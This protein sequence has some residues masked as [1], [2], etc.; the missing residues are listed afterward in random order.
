MINLVGS[1]AQDIFAL[2]AVISSLLVITSKNPAICYRKTFV[3]NKLSNSGD[4]LKLMVPN[5][6]RKVISGW[7][8]YSGM[9]TSHKMTEKEMGNRGSK[10]GFRPEKEQ[11]VDG[12]WCIQFTE[13]HLRCT[14]MG[15][16]RNYQSKILSKQLNKK[17]Y[18]TC[19]KSI[20]TQNNTSP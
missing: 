20:L 18:S 10:S 7:S 12:S 17:Y 3:G 5:Y 14:L 1:Y 9:V 11:R 19:T 2:F 15:F 16:E 4:A 6:S 13:L 8:N